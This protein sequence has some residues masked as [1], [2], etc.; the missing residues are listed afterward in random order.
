MQRR[1]DRTK[2]VIGAHALAPYART[3]Q[4]VRDIAACGVDCI[5]CMDP[6]YDALDLFAKYKIGAFVR[7]I[8][9]EWWG[10]LPAG[11]MAERNP[12]ARYEAAADAFTDHPA[13]WGIDVGDEPSAL[14][15]PHYGKVVPLVERRFPMH[16]AYLNLYPN[17][18]STSENTGEE[19]KSQ[20]GTATYQEYIDRYVAEV[21]TDYI[22]Y[23]F[24]MYANTVENAFSNL[25]TVADA[26]R[27]TGR[28]L[29]IVLQV[30]SHREDTVTSLNQMRFQAYTAMTFGAQL[31]SWGCYTK[32]WWHHN[33]LD[34]YGNKT[35]QYD[36]LAQMNAELHALGVPYMRYRRTATYFVGFDASLRGA[37]E[38][39]SDGYVKELCEASGA[40]LLVGAMVGRETAYHA[41]MLC[42]CD[43]PYDVA[44]K[45]NRVTFRAEGY[46]VVLHY[47]G[48]ETPLTPD[49][50]GIY[51][52]ELPSSHGALLEILG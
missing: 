46:D 21:P 5:V 18:A 17:Y 1:W 26:C 20:L 51:R 41:Y 4:H 38:R 43:D 48:K 13:I 6:D 14:D 37:T 9:P 27:D 32:G 36:K 52:F 29:W 23:D 50:E 7:F 30:N 34:E 12:L 31:I 40:P 8:V 2:F 49:A 11:R 35:A 44:K 3:E 19:V 28:D 25:W 15:F 42:A 39:Y 16:F 10:G 45:Q 47:G 22:S 33:V 24:Y